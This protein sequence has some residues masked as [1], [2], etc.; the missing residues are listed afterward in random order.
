MRFLDMFF[1]NDENVPAPPAVSQIPNVVVIDDFGP[2]K[3]GQDDTE[4][5][6]EDYNLWPL[7]IDQNEAGDAFGGTEAERPRSF[8]GRLF[9][10]P[11]ERLR[12][13]FNAL[14]GAPTLHDGGLLE[15][16]RLIEWERMLTQPKPQEQQ[17]DPYSLPGES[18]F[19]ANGAI[20]VAYGRMYIIGGDQE[21]GS[22]YADDPPTAAAVRARPVPQPVVYLDPY[23]SSHDCG[24]APQRRRGLGDVEKEGRD[25][26]MQGAAVL[27]RR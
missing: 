21:D 11:H 15:H 27:A 16:I 18:V 5:A 2:S 20:A 1:I 14:D 24:P 12:G 10:S 9:R 25:G 19:I 8:P 22:M 7:C 13:D 23:Q 4:Q 6:P 17:P 3:L 26:D